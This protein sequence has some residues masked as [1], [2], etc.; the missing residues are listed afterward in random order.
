MKTKGKVAPRFT[1]PAFMKPKK[2]RRVRR[3]VVIEQKPLEIPKRERVTKNPDT[4][5]VPIIITNELVEIFALNIARSQTWKERQQHLKGLLQYYLTYAQLSMI[6]HRI[7]SF[8]E[9]LRAIEMLH[10]SIHDSEHSFYI[11]S[12]GFALLEERQKVAE[13][14]GMPLM[15]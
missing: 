8:E 14:L 4:D 1:P 2:K 12:Q 3:K 7:P 6:V 5:Y 13:V 10:G 15:E 9:R 11:F